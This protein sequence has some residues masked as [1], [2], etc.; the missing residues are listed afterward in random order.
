M[1]Q[2]MR[3]KVSIED[4]EFDLKQLRS[5]VSAYVQCGER[6]VG[7]AWFHSVWEVVQSKVLFPLF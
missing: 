4:P 6:S 2:V 7:Y 5:G 3:L 1:G